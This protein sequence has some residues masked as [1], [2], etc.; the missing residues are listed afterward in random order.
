MRLLAFR[1]ENYRNIE[2][3]GWIELE[4]VTA[5]VGRNESGKTTLLKA[6]H[7]FNPAT[8]E[9]YDAQ[10]EFPR[11]RYTTQYGRQTA[12]PVCS[13]RF[14]LEGTIAAT[15]AGLL[16]QGATLP[17]TATATRRYD[18][19]LTV[20]F[21]PPLAV[22]A[23]PATAIVEALDVFGKA[24]RRLEA[25][26]PEHAEAMKAERAALM[27]WATAGK[28]RFRGIANLNTTAGVQNLEAFRTDADG[29]STPAS[30][31][32]FD[33][34]QASVEPVLDL[35]RRPDPGPQARQA[36]ADAM[37]VFIYFENYGILDSA[38]WLPRFI[39]DAKREPAAPRVRTINAMFRKV[40]LS[41]EDL[42][43]LGVENGAAYSARNQPVPPEVSAADQRRK[44]E[45]AIKLS[46]ASAAIT[47]QFGDWWSQ[48][49]HRIR[50]DAD[51]DFFR[52]WVSDHRRPN[53]EIEL[54]S[55]SK[56]FQWF[57]SFYLVFLVESDEG[58]KDAVL[59]LDE[60]GLNLHPTAQQEL[61]AFFENLSQRNQLVY[62][63]HSPFLID[64]ENLQ[65][66]RPVVEGDDGHTRVSEPGMWPKD[67][68]TIFPLQAAA[69]YAMLRNLLSR[70]DNVLVEGMTDY[71][72]LTALSH[73]CAG[74]GLAALP[75]TTHIVPCGG[76]PMVSKL[77][78][79]FLGERV[80]PLVLLDGDKAGREGRAGLHRELYKGHEADVL[81]LDDVLG[82]EGMEIE[83]LVGEKAFLAAANATS[84]SSL[85][86]TAEDRGAGGTVKAIAA[87]ARRLG[88]NLP[89]G[90]K[91]ASALKLVG[92]WTGGKAAPPPE[93]LTRAATLFEAISARLA[94]LK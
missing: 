31:D 46:S 37:P 84:A 88:V 93:A 22:A 85:T 1:V 10:R 36:V 87:A 79:L 68:E 32:L 4:Q 58:H 38:V 12:W 13:V 78:A 90:W 30:A 24:A 53:V 7:K 34:L 61:I 15:L 21:D 76:V 14:A 29:H 35:A 80:R 2:D 56:G 64:G 47:G 19:R 8:A 94:E 26:Q 20:G 55:R 6:L 44:E 91:V 25:G 48:R 50:Y 71:Y 82:G 41:A 33:A 65:R 69:G 28:D 3:S 54:E 70:H 16:P 39:E 40:G 42:Q 86:L 60:P 51:G 77:A 89:D 63:T 72:L 17:R 81:L 75:E 9:P 52:I 73:H 45:R 74:K 11:D 67:R 62:S 57:L 18:V 23:L 83:D 66:V 5:L 92:G 43:R 59:L 49:R 27:A